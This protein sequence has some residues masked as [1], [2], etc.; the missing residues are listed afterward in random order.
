MVATK[1]GYMA[2]HVFS[3]KKYSIGPGLLKE[4]LSL[5]S[6]LKILRTD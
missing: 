5:N 1:K 6:G 4:T 2:H 3:E